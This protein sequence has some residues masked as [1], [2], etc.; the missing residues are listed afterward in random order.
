MV[1]YINM[2]QTEYDDLQEK[3]AEVH[4]DILK[5]ERKIRNQ[6]DSLVSFDGGFYV[7]NISNKIVDLLFLMENIVAGDVADSFQNSE[8]EIAGFVDSVIQTDVVSN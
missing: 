4:N 1:D 6:I 7:K 3:L 8:Q 5:G 2:Q